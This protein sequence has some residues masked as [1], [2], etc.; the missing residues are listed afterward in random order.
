MSTPTPRVDADLIA[1]LREDLDAADFTIDGVAAVLGPLAER[2]LAR[3]QLLPAQRV[4][5]QTSTP[6]STLIRLFVLGDPVD[7]VEV[8]AALPALGVLG[9]TSLRLVRSE[10]DAVIAHCDLRPYADEEH[11]WWVASDLAESATGAPLDVDHVLGIG[12]ASTTLAT[13]TPRTRVGRALDIGTGCGVQ[14]LHLSTHA[15]DV[16]VTDVSDRALAFTRFN[17]ALNGQSW[18]V[19]AGSMLEPVAGQSFDLVVSNP[20]FV[21]T[22]RSGAVPLFEYRDGG[23]AGDDVVAHLV[24]SLGAVL[25]PGG[26]A[27][28]LGNWEIP[29]GADWR[30]RVRDWIEGTGLDAWVVQREVQDPAEYAEIWARDGG[31]HPGTAEFASMYAAWLDDF[32]SRGVGAIG[33]GIITLHRPRKPRETFLD[34]EEQRGVMSGPMGAAVADGVAAR[35]WLAEHTEDEL[36]ATPWGVAPGVTEERIGRPGAADP[37]AIALRQGSGVHRSMQLTSEGAAYVSVADGD[38]TPAQAIVAVAAVTQSDEA[39]V[40]TGVLESVQ[41]AVRGGFLIR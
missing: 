4:T 40:R 37:S 1:A 5:A 16:T 14:A 41:D 6:A 28:L 32:A 17:A 34:L 23:R 10:G 18:S 35:V 31:H 13:W 22:P 21:I 15:E 11:H 29:E 8:A 25:A 30:E 3:G 27:Q 9:A 36:L 20:P 19:V 26:V 33:F 12:G 24:G 39:G 2:A 7:A 38:I